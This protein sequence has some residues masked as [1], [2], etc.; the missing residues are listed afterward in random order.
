MIFAKR[1]HTLLFAGGILI[2]GLLFGSE[3]VTEI[4]TDGFEREAASADEPAEESDGDAPATE[5]E[6]EEDGGQDFPD[7]EEIVTDWV[8]P[9][10]I[11]EPT[12]STDPDV[13][14]GDAAP[15]PAGEIDPPSPPAEIEPVP[16][17]DG[18]VE[19]E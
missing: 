15:G 6:A 19:F 13:L 8:E 7:D 16:Y 18:F 5:S 4:L 14:E 17:N 12:L 2:L 11:G 1:S 9:D 3:R 10:L